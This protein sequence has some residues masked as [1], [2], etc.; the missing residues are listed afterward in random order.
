[1]Q[2][3]LPFR[4]KASNCILI[5]STAHAAI[6][7]NSILYSKSSLLY[8]IESQDPVGELLVRA[9]S[10]AYAMKNKLRSGANICTHVCM[11]LVDIDIMNDVS[12]N[13]IFVTARAS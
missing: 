8:L 2:Q 12:S 10:I 7:L 4:P 1:M 3:D 13:S 6:R 5:L 9:S 11:L